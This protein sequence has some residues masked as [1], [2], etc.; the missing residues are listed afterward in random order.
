MSFI[1]KIETYFL[2]DIKSVNYATG[3]KAAFTDSRTMVSCH[4]EIKC[5]VFLSSFKTIHMAG[6]CLRIC[7]IILCYDPHLVGQSV[8]SI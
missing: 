6:S 5:V 8:T 2:P 7:E 4:V 3:D 1:A